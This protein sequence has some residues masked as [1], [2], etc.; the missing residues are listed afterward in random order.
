MQ[1][2]QCK[3]VRRDDVY[4]DTESVGFLECFLSVNHMIRIGK[5]GKIDTR[6]NEKAKRNARAKGVIHRRMRE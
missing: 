5:S 2:V 6:K 3:A 4:I 1:G